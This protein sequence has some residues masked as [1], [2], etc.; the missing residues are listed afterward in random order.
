VQL[1]DGIT[2][3]HFHF[4]VMV[5]V[6]SLYQDWLPF[7]VGLLIVV[8]HHGLMGTIAPHHV[9]STS[10]AQQDPWLWAGIHGAFVLAASLAHL[11]SWRLNEE[12]VLQDQLTGLAN[13]T[14]LEERLARL[15]AGDGR[16]TLLV[17]DLDGFKDV[18]DAR[19]HL[20]G[21][22]VLREVA[23]RLRGCVRAGDLVARLG[24]DEF[25]VVA[26]G[27]PGGVASLGERVLAAVRVPLALPDGSVVS[28]SGSLGVATPGDAEERTA[29]ALLRNADLAMYLAKSRGGDGLAVYADGM[30][31]R[32]RDRSLLQQD[33]LG[34]TAAGQ[35]RVH[36]QPVV[37]GADGTPV[38]FEALVRWQHPERGLVPPAEFIPLAE[39]TGVVTDI[40]RWVLAE[41]TRQC[42]TWSAASGRPL[43]MSVNL[44]PRQILEE[45]IPS[46]V[47]AV[48]ADS[49]LP[50]RQL[51]LEVTEGVFVHDVDRVVDQLHRLRELGVRIAIDDFGTGF[52]S[53]SYLRRL[54]ADVLKIDR[55]FV[56]DLPDSRSS[57]S[58][59]ASIIELAHTLQL[60]VVA[61]GVETD[62]Q[63]RCLVELG[64][65]LAQG[66][67]FARPR[68]AEDCEGVGEPA[69]ATVA[70]G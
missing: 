33:L 66:Y 42:A 46:L 21:D 18:N 24:G 1:W 65:G 25:A 17:L 47:A 62:A 20:D 15:L 8:L 16:V 43:R 59:V 22:A 56:A 5:G 28:L 60:D 63:R 11:A 13:R 61:E 23:E 19:G 37:H 58:L 49:G 70:A 53:L 38:G 51:T 10:G 68:P 2:E 36:Y 6:V 54:P 26:A 27:A 30:A 12:Q 4:F 50:A 48:L 52:S 45:D 57:A 41:A 9:F 14:M 7:G 40:G 32:A 44:S 55:S 69:V 34:A 35:L 29:T 39:E 31:E 67:L 64:C 3:A